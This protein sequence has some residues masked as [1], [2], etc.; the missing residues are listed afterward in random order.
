ME[1]CSALAMVAASEILASD[2]PDRRMA[3]APS[4]WLNKYRTVCVFPVPGLP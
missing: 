1:G 3:V 2:P 4:L